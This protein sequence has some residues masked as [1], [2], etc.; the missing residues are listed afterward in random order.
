MRFE[1]KAVDLADAARLAARPIRGA[2]TVPILACLHLS[3][4]GGY[5]RV[6]G[7]NMDMEVQ[8]RL[9]ASCSTHGAVNVSAKALLSILDHMPGDAPCA[10]EMEDRTVRMA[11]ASTR[12]TLHVNEEEF[13]RFFTKRDGVKVTGLGEAMSFCKPVAPPIGSTSYSGMTLM[14]GSMFA[15]DGKIVAKAPLAYDGPRMAIPAEAAPIIAPILR[16]GGQAF[17][18]ENW[19]RVE[20]EDSA[21]SGKAL[22]DPLRESARDLFVA[23]RRLFS[24]AADEMTAAV[25]AAGTAGAARIVIA[26]SPDRMSISGESYEPGVDAINSSCACSGSGEWTFIMRPGQARTALS[27]FSGC[28]VI[29][30]DAGHGLLVSSEGR[31]GFS[32]LVAKFADARTVLPDAVVRAAE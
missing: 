20:G 21:I 29:L 19:W 5:V 4:E 6:I 24:C 32:I 25:E 31:D 16:G 26:V 23:G 9:K 28:D 10:V 8:S 2:Q 7:T 30:S 17:V 11:C 22:Q 18:T 27:Q 15:G 14:S 3:A 13:P 1:C 12:A